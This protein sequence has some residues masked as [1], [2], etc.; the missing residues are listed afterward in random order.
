MERGVEGRERKTRDP[1]PVGVH[2]D[3]RQ[4]VGA[5]EQ[6]RRPAAREEDAEDGQDVGREEQGEANK[7]MESLQS[8]PGK[9]LFS[10]PLTAPARVWCHSTLM[11]P[12]P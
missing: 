7:I 4:Y 12:V 10:S 1:R 5:E 6:P 2:G 8:T 3:H 11:E 9:M